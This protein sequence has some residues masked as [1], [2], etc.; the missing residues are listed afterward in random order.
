MVFLKKKTKEHIKNEQQGAKTLVA[1]NIFIKIKS[2]PFEHQKIVWLW[3]C[4]L[5]PFILKFSKSTP[6]PTSYVSLNQQ[7]QKHWRTLEKHEHYC[8]LLTHVRLLLQLI[9]AWHHRNKQ[10]K[11]KVVTNGSHACNYSSFDERIPNL[12]S[13]FKSNKIWPH[14]FSKKLKKWQNIQYSIF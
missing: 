9:C 7:Q 10:K 12:V 14:F 2:H 4:H 11:V 3:P 13:Q 1:I 8:I 6:D 5:L